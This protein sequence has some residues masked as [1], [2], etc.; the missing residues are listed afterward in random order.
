MLKT[1]ALNL[2]DGW[3]VTSPGEAGLDSRSLA[4]ITAWIEEIYEY[5]NTHAVLIESAGQLV[6]ELYLK[7]QD[8]VF[9]ERVFNAHSLHDLRS[10]SK[11]VTSLLLGIALQ[12]DYQQAL[13]T[14]V[15]DLFKDRDIAFA[16][17]AESITLFH[18]LTMTAGLEWD[19]WTL[20]FHDPQNDEHRLYL[21]ADPIAEVLERPLLDSPGE[22]WV[23]SSGLTELLVEIIEQKTSRRFREFAND[24]LFGP[25]GITNY[26]WYGSR[27]W[28][29]EGRPGAAWGLRMRA[30]DLARIGSLVLHDGLWQGQRVVP[31]EWIK[32]STHRHVE[33]SIVGA[34]GRYGYGFQWWPGRSNAIPSYDIIAGF[35]N[36]G[37]QL[38]IVPQLQLSVTVLAGNYS[39]AGQNSFNWFLDRIVSAHRQKPR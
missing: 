29:G 12:G 26:E 17:G 32:L 13:A 28:Q 1:T 14:P 4:E 3:P 2:R 9:G 24:T 36:G 39:R 11:S 33:E 16:P 15:A 22:S 31:S 25:L 35:G 27:H 10:I 8:G 37:Q 5:Q 18:V 20:P 38:L 21:A 23:Y 7:G 30:R 19:Q 34:R 6:Y